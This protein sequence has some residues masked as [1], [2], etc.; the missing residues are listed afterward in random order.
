MAIQK[1][2]YRKLN[3]K[4]SIPGTVVYWMSRDQRVH[5]NWA[6]ALAQEI[7]K[8]HGQQ[9]CVVFSLVP[10]FLQ[11]QNDHI[12]F[13]LEGLREVASTLAGYGIPFYLLKGSPEQ[14]IPEFVATQQA[15]VLLTDFSPLKISRTWK[16]NVAQAIAVEMIE[17]DAHNIIPAWI[18]SPKQEFAAHTIRPK[19]HSLLP[20]YLEPFPAIQPQQAVVQTTNIPQEEYT[21]TWIRSGESAAQKALQLFF[22]TGLSRYGQERNNPNANAQSQLSPYLHFGQISAQDIVLQLLQRNRSDIHLYTNPQ[23]NGAASQSSEKAFLEELIVRKELAENFCFYNA[24]YDT[25]E[26]FP[27]WARIS[28]DKHRSDPREYLYSYQKFETGTTHDPLWNAAQLQLVTIGKMHGYVRMYWAKKIL[29]WTTSPQEALAF[30]IDLNDTYSLDGRDPNGYAGIA[31][32]IGGVHDR[33]WFERPV[34][35]SIRYMSYNGCKRKFNVDQYIETWTR[36]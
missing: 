9:L 36:V 20:E 10:Q 25:I 27:Q 32:S 30:A 11:A 8:E 24:N 35:G 7:A 29:E 6:L 14:T 15:G 5:A 16:D 13:M 18:A 26:G 3:S 17:V 4:P 23:R 1:T 21:Y 28:L 34:F 31:W 19:I 33:P 2:R 22:D 12:S